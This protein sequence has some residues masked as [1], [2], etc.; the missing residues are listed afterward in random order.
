MFSGRCI[1]I[2]ISLARLYIE[3][4]PTLPGSVS[5][6]GKDAALWEVTI[7]LRAAS[8]SEHFQISKRASVRVRMTYI[9]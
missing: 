2:G 5:L 7:N 4:Q 1:A 8:I 3:I 6:S 9:H